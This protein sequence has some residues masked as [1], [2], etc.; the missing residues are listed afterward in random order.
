MAA[1][2]LVI[3]LVPPFACGGS[4]GLAAVGFDVCI[5]GGHHGICSSLNSRFDVCPSL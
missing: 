4:V 5:E 2:G 3:I 1:A